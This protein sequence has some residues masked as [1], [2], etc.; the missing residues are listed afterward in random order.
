M[1]T[2][3]EHHPPDDV[4]GTRTGTFSRDELGAEIAR[5]L[6]DPAIQAEV[7]RIHARGTHWYWRAWWRLSYMPYVLVGLALDARSWLLRHTALG[8]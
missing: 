3:Q 5:M 6:A 1:A 7:T 8:E 2:P 4:L